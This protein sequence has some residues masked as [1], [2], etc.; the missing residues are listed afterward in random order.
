MFAMRKDGRK[1]SVMERR[2]SIQKSHDTGLYR[3]SVTA[4]S[5]MMPR[6][7]L[8]ATPMRSEVADGILQMHESM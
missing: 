8:D 6:V 2:S 7:S 4:V 1:M 5:S 3:S